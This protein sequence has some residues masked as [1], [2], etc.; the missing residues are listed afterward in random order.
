VVAVV[1]EHGDPLGN[2]PIE[3]VQGEDLELRRI[4]RRTRRLAQGLATALDPIPS[5]A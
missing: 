4:P 3:N 5:P 1:R 2:A